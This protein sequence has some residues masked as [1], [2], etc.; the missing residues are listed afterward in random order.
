MVLRHAGFD[1]DAANS[2]KEFEACIAQTKV[3]YALYLLGHTVPF[4]E[5]DRIAEAVAKSTTLVYKLADIVTP[6]QLIGEVS[7]LLTARST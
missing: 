4:T 5:Q 7:K 2:A 3:P 6:Q 1:V